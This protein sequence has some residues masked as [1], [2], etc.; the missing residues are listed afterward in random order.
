MQYQGDI[1]KLVPFS[2]DIP[3]FKQ[4]KVGQKVVRIASIGTD[5][6]YGHVYTVNGFNADYS[7]VIS[8]EEKLE[9]YA[10]NKFAPLPEE[11]T[12]DTLTLGEVDK[13]RVRDLHALIYKMEPF[14]KLVLIDPKNGVD[15]TLKLSQLKNNGY[16]LLPPEPIKTISR[17]EAEK[18]LAEK[19]V[20]VRIGE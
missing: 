6:E 19:G 10:I 15:K 4:V 11:K 3:A 13:W 14:V 8:V 5:I 17:A 18:L 20:E 7:D 12:F 2:K 1:T 16:T 9:T